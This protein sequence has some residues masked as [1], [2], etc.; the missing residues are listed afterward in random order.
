MLQVPEQTT[1]GLD[2]ADCSFGGC[3]LRLGDFAHAIRNEPRTRM[4]LRWA[5][6]IGAVGTVLGIWLLTTEDV[7]TGV[8]ALV[9]G[10]SCFAAHNAPD[11]AASRW[12]QKTPRE[13]RS[14][15]YTVNPDALIVVSDVSQGAY[16]FRSLEGYFQTSESFL[17]W[18]NSRSFLI[19]PKRAFKPEDVPR[20]AA[21]LQREVGA[22]PE[23]PRYWTWLLLSGA[24]ALALLWLWNRLLPR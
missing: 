18:V 23:L 9:L 22:P 2:L 17:L 5:T 7:A 8:G 24:A 14:L 21:R 12:Y 6:V 3:T 11:Q 10:L 16:Q 20:I 19:V 13:A 1:P 4:L 15:R